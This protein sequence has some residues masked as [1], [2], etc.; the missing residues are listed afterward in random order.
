MAQAITREE[1]YLEAMANGTTTNI[2][3]V[4]RE[5]MYLAKAT[6]QNVTVPKPVTRKEMFLQRVALNGGGTGGGGG[7]SAILIEKPIT[8]NGTYNAISDGADGYSKVTVNV[9]NVIPDGYIKP[10]GTKTITNNGTHDVTGFASATVNVPTGI[11]P[12]GTKPITENGIHD[13]TEYASVSVSVASSG[14]GK[15]T[16]A[17][18]LRARG[19]KYLFYNTQ[20]TSAPLFDTSEFTDMSNM[21]NICRKLTTVPLYNTSKV[22]NMTSMFDS[23]DKLTTVPMFDTSNVT[24]MRNMFHAD[25]VLTEVPLF[26]TSKVTDMYNMFSDCEVL[27][28]IPLF[29]TRNVTNVSS[30]FSGCNVLTTV[31]ELDIRRASSTNN[32]FYGCPRLTDVHIKNIKTNLTVGSGTTYGHLLTVDSLVHLIYELR[33]TNSARTLTVGSANLEK[34]ANVYVKAIDI[35]DEMRAEDDLIDEKYPFVVCESTDEGATLIT[36]YASDYKMWTIK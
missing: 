13:V 20:I 19:I 6:G 11:T 27:T 16:L 22:T 25:Y 30:M 18:F 28:T 10:S 36:D 35:T 21:F 3:P 5:E 8:A 32:I 29:D 31:P 24:T 9:P 15:D 14:D 17:E 26:N 23:C 33:N 4:T 12:T 7:A 1:Q 2:N 34:L